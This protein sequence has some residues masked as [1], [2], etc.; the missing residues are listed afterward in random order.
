[1]GRLIALAGRDERMHTDVRRL[2]R[3]TRELPRRA[4]VDEIDRDESAHS[5]RKDRRLCLAV[6]RLSARRIIC[7]RLE[8]GLRGGAQIDRGEVVTG[9][10]HPLA[11]CTPAQLRGSK[12]TI[13]FSKGKQA[14]ESPTSHPFVEGTSGPFARTSLGWVPTSIARRPLPHSRYRIS[15]QSRPASGVCF[16]PRLVII[17]HKFPRAQQGPEARVL[18]LD[19]LESSTA[20]RVTYAILKDKSALRSRT[21]R[22]IR[23]RADIE[24]TA[25]L[26]LIDVCL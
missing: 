23:L 26:A 7:I 19:S 25:L 21:Y 16:M 17:G 13:R 9:P 1:M 14:C 8:E 22:I 6:R 4:G 3:A 11:G 24:A 15:P 20:S 10:R 5:S 12:G 18:V 2:K